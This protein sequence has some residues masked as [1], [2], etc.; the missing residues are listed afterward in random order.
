MTN[1][2]ACVGGK[3]AG[4]SIDLPKSVFVNFGIKSRDVISSRSGSQGQHDAPRLRWRP[5]AA[6]NDKHSKSTRAGFQIKKQAD[7]VSASKYIKQSNAAYLAYSIMNL[8]RI[9]SRKSHTFNLNI[10]PFRQLLD[11]YTASCR[12]VLYPLLIFRIHLGEVPHIRQEYLCFDNL[13][14]RGAGFCQ[15]CCEGFQARFSS[16]T[17]RAFNDVSLCICW[18]LTGAVYS[19]WCFDGLG[20][21]RSDLARD[22]RWKGAH[23]GP[24][25]CNNRQ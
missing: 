20:L 6:I 17:H 18:K 7:Q 5:M 10:N 14:E 8:P 21:E 3:V 13:V 19:M 23:I 25:S 9:K 11:R 2:K 16:L 4:N 1:P 12:F 15:D 22:L 24:N